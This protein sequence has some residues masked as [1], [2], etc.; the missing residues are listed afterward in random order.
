MASRLQFQNESSH[1]Q[2][3]ISSRSQLFLKIK[4]TYKERTSETYFHMNGLASQ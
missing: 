1:F 4:W 2:V 3:K